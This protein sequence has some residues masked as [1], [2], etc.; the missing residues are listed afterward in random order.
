M[1]AS[2]NAALISALQSIVGAAHVLTSPGSTQRYRTGFRFGGGPV[3]AVVRPGTLVEQW[4]VLQACVAA[5]K[6]II[7]QA[8]NTGLTG[9][10]T[11]DGTDYDRDIVIIST[12]RI[13]KVRVIGEGRQ[14]VCLPGAT[15]YQLEKTLAPLGRDPHSVIGSSCIG[16]S[17][18]GGVCNNSGGAL[19]HRGP[20]Y[21]EMTLFAR[22]DEEGAVQLVNHLGIRLG[23]DAEAI[24]GRL[25]RD[26]FTEGDIDYAGDRVASDHEYAA[27]V[28]D[29]E[30][31]TPGRFNADPRR[32]HESAGSAGKVM[33]FAV[34]LD[35]FPKNQ[36]T[37]V[38]YIGTNDAAELT[39]IRRHI[40][41]TFPDLPLQGEY[42]HRV[43]YDIAAEYGKDTF[44]AIRHLG[45][46]VMPKLFSV[47]GRLDASGLF[48]TGFTDRV[49][50]FVAK[51][52]P[53][54]LPRRM[55]EFRDRYEHHLMLKVVGDS[56]EATRAYLSSLFPSAAGGF[57]ECTDDEGQR[58]FL[59]RF[60]A[61]G[62]A[63]RYRAVH[64]REV[65]DIVALDIALRRND[66]DWFET[67]PA[68]LEAPI[69]HKLYYGHFFCHVFHQDYIIAKGHDPVAIE[70][71]MWA[72]LDQ[73]GA[74]YPAE[75]NVGHLYNAKPALTDHY[76][77]LDPQ[78]M[79]NPGIGHTSKCGHWH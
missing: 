12:L 65:E 21:T 45:T 74:E 72:L 69:L 15:L 25:D 6:I 5:G 16:A 27:H 32:L 26:D 43:A 58:A 57:F 37:K 23:D 31:A 59:H 28:R 24:L 78:N 42:M 70:H 52:F 63:I 75:H 77:A 39:A 7:M 11:P 14:V 60:A 48:P 53:H 76:R 30:A 34:R 55:T 62:A 64:P 2:D 13:A 41:G 47:K 3:L 54:H 18:F 36:T 8:A 73:R 20:A 4:R 10:S 29:I 71:G 38:F 9:G 33:V 35:T 22:V 50:Q 51:L 56:I 40:L 46:E 19:I 17:V 79:F 44:L 68:A 61:A 49:L 1:S 66:Q 67:L